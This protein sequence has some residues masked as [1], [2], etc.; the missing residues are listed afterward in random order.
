MQGAVKKKKKKNADGQ[1]LLPEILIPAPV[2][3]SNIHPM[4]RINE[5]ED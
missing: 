4:L 2:S 1:F 5:F 3:N